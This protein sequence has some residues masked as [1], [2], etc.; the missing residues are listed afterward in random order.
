MR[1]RQKR[2]NFIFINTSAI[3]NLYKNNHAQFPHN[4]DGK[5]KNKHYKT[6]FRKIKAKFPFISDPVTKIEQTT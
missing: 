6:S 3:A 1:L 2:K 5:S 4:T